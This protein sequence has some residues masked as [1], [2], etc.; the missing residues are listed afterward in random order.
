[1]RKERGNDGERGRERGR[2]EKERVDGQW[3]RER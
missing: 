3:G 2:E 1:M